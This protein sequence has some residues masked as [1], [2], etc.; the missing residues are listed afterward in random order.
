[1]PAESYEQTVA[2][3]RSEASARRWNPLRLVAVFV[4]VFLAL[5]SSWEACRGSVLE[6]L[7]I[8]T[9]TVEP[10]AWVIDKLSP[11]TEV[12]A[13]ANAIVSTT[14]RI[15]VLNGCEGLELAFLLTA[16]FLAYPMPWRQRGIGITGSL[17][18]AYLANQLRLVVLWFAYAHDRELFALIHGTV[19]PLILV[20]LCLL[21]FLLFIGRDAVRR[22]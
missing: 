20:A 1:M 4:V 21:Y 14:G 10:A 15:N 22:S 12:R 18:L 7:L 6:R 11:G 13:Q 19:G 3:W 2:R 8:D 16:A 17:L 5:Q 9:A